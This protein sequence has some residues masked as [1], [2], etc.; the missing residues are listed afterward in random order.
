MKA[1][2]I[3]LLAMGCAAAPPGPHAELHISTAFTADQ[4]DTIGAAVAQWA[5]ATDG[6]FALRPVVTDDR[7]LDSWSIRPGAL[8]GSSEIGREMNGAVMIDVDKM[9]AMQAPAFVF[10]TSVL[11]ELGHGI[12]MPHAP[13]GLMRSNITDVP[14]CIDEYT[15]TTACARV[16]CGEK[17]RATCRSEG[18]VAR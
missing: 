12:G 3:G 11:H 5:R 7:D 9:R 6:G 13:I 17:K 10:L 18:V 1:L 16:D 8:E 4:Q 14:A 2:I 15:L